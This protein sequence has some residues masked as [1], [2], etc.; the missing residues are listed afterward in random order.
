M[1][2]SAQPGCGGMRAPA[3]RHA[4]SPSSHRQK[5]PQQID[6]VFREEAFRVELHTVD[7]E[8]FVFQ[9]HDLAPHAG[10]VDPR[11]HLEIVVQAVGRTSRLW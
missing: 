1:K 2:E 10:V 3:R 5:V 11:G 8:A 7:R 4:D 9:A 6:P